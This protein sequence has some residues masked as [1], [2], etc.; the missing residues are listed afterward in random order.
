MKKPAPAP[1]F[2]AAMLRCGP[3]LFQPERGGG[4]HSRAAIEHDEGCPRLGRL[5]IGRR[6]SRVPPA[7]RTWPPGRT[8]GPSTLRR[9]S[10]AGRRYP[11]ATSSSV[12]CS[13]RRRKNPRAPEGPSSNTAASQAVVF[14]A[15]TCPVPRPRAVSRSAPDSGRAAPAGALAAGR[16]RTAFNST[17][18]GSGAAW[19][20]DR[21]GVRGL[22]RRLV[23]HSIARSPAAAKATPTAA[24][25]APASTRR[26]EGRAAFGDGAV[27]F[28][29]GAASA[30]RAVLRARGRLL[31]AP[32]Q[33]RSQRRTLDSSR[34]ALQQG[35]RIVDAL[36][37]CVRPSRATCT[38]A[39][40]RS[41][42]HTFTMS[43]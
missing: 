9:T 41:G 4:P 31:L 5:G 1:G 15:D 8:R 17:S 43:R 13:P 19:H 18:A 26:P 39:W 37:A 28:G 40:N 11:G 7:G 21:G 36:Q 30:W 29:A 34:S 3:Q 6:R 16:R 42:C 38:S 27:A 20:F 12:T 33:S 25:T 14:C 23:P 32:C 24:P 10:P 2:M 35:V 22:R